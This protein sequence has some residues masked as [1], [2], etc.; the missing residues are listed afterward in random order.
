MTTPYSIVFDSFLGKIE[1]NWFSSLT[2]EDAETDMVKLLNSAI[3]NFEYPK[4]NIF[5]KDDAALLFTEDL[6]I[7]EVD[8]I[9]I[10]MKH[11]WVKRDINSTKKLKQLFSSS[12]F[13]LTS[14]AAHLESL[15]KLEEVTRE[16]IANRKVKYSY[17][18]KNNLPDYAGLSGEG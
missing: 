14:Q 6:S 2:Q 12:D 18:G 11:E 8:I 17:R 9:A 10:L 1:D 4:V 13:R 16:E 5:D 7:F 15:L 3:V